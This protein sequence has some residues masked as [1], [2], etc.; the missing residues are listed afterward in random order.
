MEFSDQVLN[1]F[2]NSLESVWARTRHCRVEWPQSAPL[3]LSL[4]GPLQA[5]MKTS[6]S[7]PNLSTLS[8]SGSHPSATLRSVDLEKRPA[9]DRTWVQG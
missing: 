3:V 5:H 9:Q 2:S 1:L 7:S 4:Q 8:P 6:A